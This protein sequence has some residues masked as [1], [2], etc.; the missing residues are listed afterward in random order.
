MLLWMLTW[1]LL[2]WMLT[3]LLT[4]VVDV[5]VV[6][7]VESCENLKSPNMSYEIAYLFKSRLILVLNVFSPTLG[8]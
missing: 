4:V 1:L 7:V 2:L 3:L 8:A 5:E 6:V